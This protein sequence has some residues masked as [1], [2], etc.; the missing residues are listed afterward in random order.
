MK[1]AL[2]AARPLPD[3]EKLRAKRFDRKLQKRIE[4][5]KGRYAEPRAALIPILWEC[6]NRWGWI[7]P[8]TQKTISEDLGLSPSTVHG[9]VSFYT[10]FHESRPGRH[11]LQV[12]GTLSCHLSGSEEVASHLKKRLGV[13]FGQTTDDGLFTLIQVECLG[14]CDEGPVLRV[15][16][17]QYGKMTPR[18][19]DRLLGTLRKEANA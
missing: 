17:T 19:V 12:C 14:A 1:R 13:D 7:S 2:Q 11:V 5:L 9:V 10:M 6:Q 15:D 4:D 3:W 16:D 18:K 8:E